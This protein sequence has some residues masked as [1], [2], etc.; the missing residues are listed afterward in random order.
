LGLIAVA[1]ATWLYA[2]S[3]AAA[4]IRFERLT[5]Q[6]A[7]LDD[8][9]F[10]PG[11]RGI[12]GSSIDNAAAD[13]FSPLTVQL[14]TPGSQPYPVRFDHVWAVSTDQAA[15]ALNRH[16]I[17]AY[18]FAG[19]LALM[20]LNGGAPRPVLE[21]IEFADFLPG[22]S[23]DSK[24]L[25]SRFH[26]DARQCTLEYPIGHVLYRTGGWIGQ[27]RFSRDGQRIAF[28]D[29]PMPGDDNGQAA[30]VDLAGHERTLGPHF[31]ET[32]GLAWSPDGHE[33]WYT[34]GDS[35]Q[36]NLYAV[37][38]S[39][40]NRLLLSAPTGLNLEDVLPSGQALIRSQ[41]KRLS[42]MV[43]TPDH[44][45]PRDFSVLDWPYTAAGSAD[46]KI[47]LIGDQDA[48]PDY[49]TYLRAADGSPPV[50]L[51]SGDP[52]D[53]SPDGQWALSAMPGAVVQL[54]LLPTG[55][56][57]PRQLTRGDIS[58]QRAIFLP[59]GRGVVGFG[60]QAGHSLRTYAVDW[61]GQVRPVTPEGVLGHV[62]TPDGK[63]VLGVTGAQ[64]ALYP[65]AGGAPRPVAPGFAWRGVGPLRFSDSHTLL[66]QQF[67]S[68]GALQVFSLDLN[69]GA[70]QNRFTLPFPGPGSSPPTLS[71]ISSDANSYAFKYFRQLDTYYLVT[72][73]K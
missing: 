65:L 11:G 52:W 8:A 60:N 59:D 13:P 36:S 14:D 66:A 50:R 63:D 54:W 56:G 7:T 41:D 2:R 55:A 1:S 53:L 15:V 57:S 73:L 3:Q 27:P 68:G 46:G 32:Q 61:N 34:G 49:A 17:S 38:L 5:Y 37:S 24:L 48:G 26:P 33:V 42:M 47:F 43:V 18:E 19:T 69:S 28:L 72:G 31:V 9:Y 62:A 70:R 44:P 12:L 39:G 20:P 30:V 29:H 25:I 22:S 10:L 71:T 58:W 6:Q 40:R 4:P 67:G 45:Q 16:I 21:N 23:D 35:T 64:A 51:G